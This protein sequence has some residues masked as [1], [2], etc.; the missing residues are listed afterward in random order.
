M[1]NLVNNTVSQYGTNYCFFFKFLLLYVYIIFKHM[2][3]CI[4]NASVYAKSD[5]FCLSFCRLYTIAVQFQVSMMLKE[6]KKRFS[7]FKRK[8][9]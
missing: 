9:E 7:K 6:V 4:L 3:H 1:L 5:L 8:F 2:Q